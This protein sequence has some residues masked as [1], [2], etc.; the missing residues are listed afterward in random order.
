MKK[1]SLY[2]LIAIFTM[3]IS[4]M[5]FSG[6]VSYANEEISVSSITKVNAEGENVPYDESY[7]WDVSINYSFQNYII[8]IITFY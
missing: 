2:I 1:I 3:L 8:Y 7:S 4:T 5:L 6:V